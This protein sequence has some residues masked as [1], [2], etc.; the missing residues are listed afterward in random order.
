MNEDLKAEI[1]NF[2]QNIRDE[3]HDDIND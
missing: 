3:K 1:G 2:N